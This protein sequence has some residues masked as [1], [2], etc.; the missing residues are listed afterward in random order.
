MTLNLRWV[1][2]NF[3]VKKIAAREVFIKLSTGYLVNIKI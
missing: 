1:I 3:Q 2:I